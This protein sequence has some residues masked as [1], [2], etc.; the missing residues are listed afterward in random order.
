MIRWLVQSVYNHPDLARGAAPPGLLSQA[1]ADHLA[2]LSHPKRRQDWLL[3]RWT[4]KQLLVA[5]LSEQGE[6]PSLEEITV[7]NDPAGAPYAYFERCT[8]PAQ[9]GQAWANGGR[10]PVSLTISHSHG[11][12]F[13]ALAAQPDDQQTTARLPRVGGDVEQIEAREPS[14]GRDFFTAEERA[15]VAAAPPVQR[16]KLATVIWSAKESVLKALHL[17]LSVDTRL[18]TCTLGG[19]PAAD[20]TPIR[21]TLHGHLAEIAA[22]QAGWSYT[23]SAWW[24]A[25]EMDTN[26]PR[27]VLTLC[28][29]AKNG[30]L[31]EVSAT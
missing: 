17:G 18:V 9:P 15:V 7:G 16:D 6:A 2:R 19:A 24:R 22:E 3:G 4:A 13:C 29:F 20:W 5:T 8:S 31:E 26:C 11:V 27:Q 1:E 25:C 10:I 23:L 12:A 28:A 21:V 14:F 30:F